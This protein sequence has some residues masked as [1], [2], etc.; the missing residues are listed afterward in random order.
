[1]IYINAFFVCGSIC[2]IGQILYD[3]TNFTPGH[4]TSLFVVLG[5]FLDFFQLYDLLLNFGLS[6][7]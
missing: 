6:N 3:N 4:I 2:L 7:R 1:M 5:C